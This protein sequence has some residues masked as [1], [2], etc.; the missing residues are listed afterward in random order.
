MISYKPLFML[1]L[2]KD[3]KKVQLRDACSISPGTLAKLSKGE[4]VSLEVLDRICLYL[5]CQLSDIAEVL[6]NKSEE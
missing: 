3:M 5:N 6:P 1:L 2:Q 4:Y